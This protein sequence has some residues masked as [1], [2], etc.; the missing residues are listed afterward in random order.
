[1][2]VLSAGARVRAH[3]HTYTHTWKKPCVDRLDDLPGAMADK[4]GCEIKSRIF[5]L[6]AR[7]DNGHNIYIACFVDYYCIGNL[8]HTR[9]YIFFALMPKTHI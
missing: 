8:I 7:L 6:S 5:V 9:C 3:T 4:D 1:M 2:Q